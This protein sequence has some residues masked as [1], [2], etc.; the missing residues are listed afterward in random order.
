MSSGVAASLRRIIVANQH[1]RLFI[2]SKCSPTQIHR[3][4]SMQNKDVEKPPHPFDYV[5][6]NYSKKPHS[7]E[8]TTFIS[9]FLLF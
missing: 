4:F 6:N 9:N 1:P 2:L 5:N 3:T 7:Q 8:M